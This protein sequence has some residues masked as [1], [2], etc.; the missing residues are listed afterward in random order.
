MDRAEPDR[1]GELAMSLKDR[2]GFGIFHDEPFA[3]L[4]ACAEGAASDRDVLELFGCDA[5]KPRLV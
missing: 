3:A 1:A 4:V 5:L 2:I